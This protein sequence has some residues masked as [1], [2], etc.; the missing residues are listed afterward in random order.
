MKPAE[1]SG[2]DSYLCYLFKIIVS[3][4]QRTCSVQRLPH[5]CVFAQKGFPVI[6]NPVQD[7]P[8]KKNIQLPLLSQQHRETL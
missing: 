5:S 8:E 1:A 7:L 2:S 3:F 4:L 6:F